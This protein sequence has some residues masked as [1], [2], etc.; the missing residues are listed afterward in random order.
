MRYLED[1]LRKQLEMRCA[2][3]RCGSLIWGSFSQCAGLPS[4]FV[5]WLRLWVRPLREDVNCLLVI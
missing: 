5:A 4:A 1:V 3:E 2:E